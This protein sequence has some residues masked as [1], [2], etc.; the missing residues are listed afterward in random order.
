M[1]T[2]SRTRQALYL[3]FCEEAATAYPRFGH[4]SAQTLEIHP[5]NQ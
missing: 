5:M 2:A 4:R 3:V 1:W